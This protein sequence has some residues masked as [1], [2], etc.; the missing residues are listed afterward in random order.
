MYVVGTRILKVVESINDYVD[1]KLIIQG[2]VGHK[3]RN[4]YECIKSIFFYL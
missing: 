2:S 4:V 1:T 3:T